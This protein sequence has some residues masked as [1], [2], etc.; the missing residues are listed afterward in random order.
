M[1]YVRLAEFGQAGGTETTLLR[2]R[3]IPRVAAARTANP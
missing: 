3:G 1:S 2:T